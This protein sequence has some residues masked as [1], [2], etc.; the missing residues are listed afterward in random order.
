MPFVEDPTA[1]FTLDMPGTKLAVY[2][3]QDVVVLFDT[4]FF[5]PQ[6]G[7]LARQTVIQA[8]A[9]RLPGFAVGSTIAIDDVA[10]KCA[11]PPRREHG[12]ITAVLQQGPALP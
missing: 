10:Y 7:V 3:G 2:G 11:E 9:A 4:E 6:T 1:F 8:E 5:D 12:V